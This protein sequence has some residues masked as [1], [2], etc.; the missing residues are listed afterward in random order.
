MENI[1]CEIKTREY[2]CDVK[3]IP[4]RVWIHE[5]VHTHAQPPEGSKLLSKVEALLDEQVAKNPTA[6]VHELR[7]GTPNSV[8]LHKL[9]AALTRPKTAAYH[10]GKSRRKQGIILPS[11]S[12]AQFES[13]ST[14]GD[15]LDDNGKPFLIEESLIKGRRYL[16]F[17]TDFQREALEEMIEEWEDEDPKAEYRHG[18]VTDGNHSFFRVGVLMQTSVFLSTTAMYTSVLYTWIDGEDTEHHRPHFAR[19]A[20]S[21]VERMTRTGRF[22]K[23]YLFQVCI[24][25][26]S[27]GCAVDQ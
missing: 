8:P 22:N 4:T 24:V 14:V 20:Q 2:T 25:A 5:G 10:V 3:G 21:V 7:N 23:K 16:M 12:K 6:S 9:S 17:Q 19:L 27:C 15:I 1:R 11:K 26:P 18:M 13:I